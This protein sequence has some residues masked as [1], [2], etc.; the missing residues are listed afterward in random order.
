MGYN[1]GA[2]PILGLG[3]TANNTSHFRAMGPFRPEA[4][5]HDRRL[6]GGEQLA[7][8]LLIRRSV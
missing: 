2:C 4:A 8:R 6:F 3:G 1:L 7:C 5:P